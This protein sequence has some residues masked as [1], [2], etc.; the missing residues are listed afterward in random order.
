MGTMSSSGSIIARYRQIAVA[1]QRLRAFLQDTPLSQ[2]IAYGPVYLRGM[3]PS[4]KYVP[5]NEEHHLETLDVREL[6]YRYPGSERGIEEINL[7]L[8]RGQFVVITGRVGAGKTTLLRVMLGL[9]PQSCGQICWNGQRIED[10]ASFFVPPRSAYTAQ[11]PRLFSDTLRENMLLGLPA[12]HADL[13][14]ALYAAVSDLAQF[15]HGLDTLIGV[16]G[17]RLSGGQAHRAAAARMF[18]RDP[19]LFVFDD[20]SSA[21]DVETEQQLWQR[22]FARKET[23]CLVVSH[24]HAALSRADHIIVLKQGRIEAQGTLAQLMSTC[25]EMRQLW[26]G[27]LRDE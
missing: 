1:L 6:S 14:N 15:E 8:Y 23:T 19:E 12:E 24:R 20:L 16:H 4:P 5:K 10:A 9:L 22:L 27:Q 17:V 11:V 26:H 7:R 2:L 13:S 18:V 3:F 21:L 25:E